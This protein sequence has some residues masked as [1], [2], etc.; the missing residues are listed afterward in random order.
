MARAGTYLSQLLNKY[1]NISTAG[2]DGV[3]NSNDISA[4]NERRKKEMDRPMRRLQLHEQ[5]ILKRKRE[6]RRSSLFVERTRY[7]KKMGNPTDSRMISK[8]IGAPALNLPDGGT[9]GVLRRVA[10]SAVVIRPASVAAGRLSAP[11]KC[12]QNSP[13][14]GKQTTK[15]TREIVPP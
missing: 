11:P 10:A 9:A 5:L 3:A 7:L 8:G 15:D 12:E 2:N 6:T 1:I 14:R 4:V 13:T